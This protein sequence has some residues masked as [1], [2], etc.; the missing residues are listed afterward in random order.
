MMVS[1]IF[2]RT[3]L[4]A[5]CLMVGVAACGTDSETD[6]SATGTASASESANGGD[7]T[8]F[9]DGGDAESPT[10]TSDPVVSGETVTVD[11]AHQGCETVEDCRAVYTDC[12]ACEG[13]CAGVNADFEEDYVAA[14]ECDEYSGPVCDFDCHP[15]SGLTELL[16]DEGVCIIQAL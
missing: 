2:G 15:Q 11:E 6:D 16:C 7:D 13:G 5:L 3:L 14:L 4:T 1:R 12:S 10:E 8:Q 9:T